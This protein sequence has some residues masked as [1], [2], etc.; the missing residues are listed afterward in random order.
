MSASTMQNASTELQELRKFADGLAL[1][2]KER[3]QLQQI[4]EHNITEI[5]STRGVH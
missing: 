4:V 2:S 1:S 3:A 5:D